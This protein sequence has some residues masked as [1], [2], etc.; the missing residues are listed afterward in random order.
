M[1]DLTSIS[2]LFFSVSCNETPYSQALLSVSVR[3]YQEVSRDFSEVR[4]GKK[5][6]GMLSGR[7]AFTLAGRG[8]RAQL[9]SV[10]FKVIQHLSFQQTPLY[11]R[12]HGL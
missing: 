7:S 1:V 5:T 4:E 12:Q 10:L 11:V 2:F 8:V 3:W 6:Q 9:K